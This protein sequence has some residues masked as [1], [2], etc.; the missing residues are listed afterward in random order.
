M[1]FTFTAKWVIQFE[2]AFSSL[3]IWQIS[4]YG[5]HHELP[6]SLNHM[7]F[8]FNITKSLFY[9]THKYLTNL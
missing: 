2:H 4:T 7:C 1:R 5:P 6:N 3:W 8:F 9:Q